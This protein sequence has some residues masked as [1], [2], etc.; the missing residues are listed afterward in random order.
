ME[1]LEKIAH[2]HLARMKTTIEIAGLQYI[3]EE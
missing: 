2:T 1:A 3:K